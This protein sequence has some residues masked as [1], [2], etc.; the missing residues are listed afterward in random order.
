MP[1]LSRHC[2]MGSLKSLFIKHCFVG[3]GAVSSCALCP[4]LVCVE[5]RCAG[6]FPFYL[7]LWIS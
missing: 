1:P 2:D 5:V 3:R 6:Q 7:G 4:W